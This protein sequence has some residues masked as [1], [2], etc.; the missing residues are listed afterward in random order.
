MK[1]ILAGGGRTLFFLAQT[2]VGKGHAVTIIDRDG[3][4]CARLARDLEA[5]VVRGDASDPRVLEDAGAR[6]A[7]VVLAATPS[8]ADNLVIGQLA[9]ARFGVPRAVALVNDPENRRIFKELGID[10]I[11]TSLTVA[12]LIEQSA[13][14]DE[15]TDLIPAGGGKVT[16]SEVAITDASPV[17]GRRLAE[18]EFPKAALIAVVFRDHETLIPRGDTPLQAGDRLLLVA[19]PEAGS[20]AMEI[21]TGHRNA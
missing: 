20:R 10:A 2:F 9:K 13:A 1:V 5:T 21:L 12:S 11:S 6:S 14:F 19:L 8:D 17:A 4:E 3:S 16:I 7:N 18:I 15:I